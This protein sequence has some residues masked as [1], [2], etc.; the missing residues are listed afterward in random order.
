MVELRAELLRIARPFAFGAHDAEDLVHAAYERA[1]ERRGTI[2]HDG[3]LAGWL[4][5]LVHNVAVDRCRSRRRMV[6]LGDVELVADCPALVP[7]W[8]LVD[9]SELRQLLRGFPPELSRTYVLHFFERLSNPEI[10]ERLQIPL[11]TVA[12]RLH[13]VRGR[14]RQL[15]AAEAQGEAEMVAITGPRSLA[16][17]GEDPRSWQSV[18]RG[19]AAAPGTR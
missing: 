13:R 3:N 19:E 11:P 12:T 9:E 7:A 1:L 15:L 8:R 14:L 18:G 2:Q 4:R 16:G 6:P 17:S 10:A 5:R